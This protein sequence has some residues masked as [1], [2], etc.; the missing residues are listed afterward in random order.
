MT[1]VEGRIL[2]AEPSPPD[3]RDYILEPDTATPLPSRFTLNGLGPVLDQGDSP[4]CTAYSAIGIRQW[5]EKRDGHGVLPF[6]PP[7]LYVLTKVLEERE[8]GRVFDGAFL[9][10]V[11]RVLKGSGT[12]LES[13]LRSTK[14][15]SYWRVSDTT[16]AMKQALVQAVSP[17]YFRIDW[18][19]AWM[20][21]PWNRILKAPSGVLAGGHAVYIW[22]WDDNVNG[23]SWLIRNSWGRW[24]TAGSGNA[25]LAYRYL[26]NRNPEAWVVKDI[27]GD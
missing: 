4:M 13:G 1:L 5:H 26:A 14:I 11:L 15:E 2:N 25:Y 18:D 21:L 22:G 23:G 17:L 8:T 10:D 27:V 7:G 3:L 6:S 19:R 9:R 12:P 16:T 20:G 24:S